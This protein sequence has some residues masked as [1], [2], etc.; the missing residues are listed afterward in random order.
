MSVCTQ[1]ASIICFK[2]MLPVAEQRGGE[3]AGARATPLEGRQFRAQMHF[4]YTNRAV[5]I[6]VT[7]NLYNQ[8]ICILPDFFS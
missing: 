8:V 6:Y 3:G 2:D 5:H 1:V 7:V 4:Y